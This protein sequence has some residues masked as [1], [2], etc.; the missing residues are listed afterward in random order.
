[1]VQ[2]VSAGVWR[3]ELFASFRKVSRHKRPYTIISGKF[4][5]LV[6]PDVFSPKYFTDS[7]WF[8][9]RLPQIVK[10]GSLLEIG[11]GTGICALYCASAGATVIATDINPAAVCN[12]EINAAL[13]GRLRIAIRAGDMYDAVG[14]RKFDFIFWNHPFNSW[15]VPVSVLQRSGIDPDYRDLRRYVSEGGRH[16][17]KDGALLLGTSDM[18]ETDQIEKIAAENNYRLTLLA[19]SGEMPIEDGSDV[20]NTYLIYRFDAV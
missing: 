16:L 6:L 20:M 10:S 3:K 17:K 5:L 18:A 1:M 11:T 9:E 14:A 19:E 8:A 2:R 15:N 13:Y 12:A 7:L 4:E